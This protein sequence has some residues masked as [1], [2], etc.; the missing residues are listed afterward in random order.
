ML[1]EGY[2]R[3]VIVGGVAA[4]ASAAAKARRC[5]EKAEIILYEKGDTISYANCGLPYYVG[6]I[7]KDRDEL[8]IS[9]PEFFLER[10]NIK[11][12][13]RHEVIDVNPEGKTVTVMDHGTSATME[14]PYDKLILA[15]GADP[16]I[17]PVDGIDLPFVFTLKT[18]ADMDRVHGYLQ[19]HEVRN[20]AIVGGGLIGVEMVENLAACGIKVTVVEF[21]PQILSFLD[22]EMAAVTAHHMENK[23]VT[24]HLGDK[25]TAIRENETGNRVET[26]SGA[27]LAADLVILSVG[28]RPNTKLAVKAGLKIGETGGVWVD[29]FMRTSDPDIYAAGDCIESQHLVTGRPALVPMGSAANKEGRAAGANCL[30]RKIVVKGFCGTVIVKAFDLAVGKTGLSEREAVREGFAPVS[31]YV[32]AEHHAGYYPD[33]KDIRI[34]IVT[35]NSNGR[36]LGAQVVGAA[37]VDKRIDVFATAIFNGMRTEDLVHLDLAYAPPY[38]SA[39]D[40]VIVAGML[41]QNRAVGDWLPVSPAALHEEMEKGEKLTLVDVRTKAELRRLGRIAGAIH[42]PIDEFRERLHELC[43]TDNI[44]LYCAVGLRSYLGNRI[45]AMHDFKS[46]RTLTGGFSAW[47]YPINRD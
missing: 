33:A 28:I 5:S 20:A 14:Q 8:L 4:G 22:E 42:I 44:V 43:P 37:G 9:D 1:N 36:L 46:V 41:Q 19:T 10:F 13:T 24:L 16:I 26:A 30:G 18:L 45:L 47:N 2:E 3:I 21:L 11:A 27:S 40:P 34:K 29:A 23:G 6:G 31:T 15:T 35:D 17:P 39:R 38:S 25:V 32:L 7:I 12:K